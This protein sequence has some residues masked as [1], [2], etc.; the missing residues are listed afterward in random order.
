M[1]LSKLILTQENF[2]NIKGTC[3]IYKSI[4]HPHRAPAPEINI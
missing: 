1:Q 4:N 2:A 3:F